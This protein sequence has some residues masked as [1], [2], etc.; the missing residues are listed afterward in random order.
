MHL[1]FSHGYSAGDVVPSSPPVGLA[2]IEV[3][4]LAPIVE[5]LAG[6]GEASG[7]LAGGGRQLDQ[8]DAGVLVEQ[9]QARAG[10]QG[11][12]LTRAGLAG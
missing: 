10:R 4:A 8:L 12:Q 3:Y 11:A 7:Q 2:K 6:A 1:F 9:L 5:E